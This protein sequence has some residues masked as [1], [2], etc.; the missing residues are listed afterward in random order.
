MVDMGA[1]VGTVGALLVCKLDEVRSDSLE[2]R[3]GG[4]CHHAVQTLC[5]LV[6]VPAVKD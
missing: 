6:S 4:M 2:K 1:G 3:G 5:R